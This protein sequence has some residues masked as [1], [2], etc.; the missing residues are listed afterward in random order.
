MPTD[1][2]PSGAKFFRLCKQ[3]EQFASDFV[4]RATQAF[5]IVSNYSEVTEGT[6]IQASFALAIRC[7]ALADKDTTVEPASLRCHQAATLL[8]AQQEV[9]P[10]NS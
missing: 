6:K 8:K 3:E 1:L 5:K 9:V 2:R 4:E 7:H 10:P